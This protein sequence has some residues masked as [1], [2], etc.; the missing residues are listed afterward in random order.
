MRAGGLAAPLPP[1]GEGGGTVES[2]E[3]AIGRIKGA[4]KKPRCGYGHKNVVLTLVD[5]DT[6]T[7]RSFHVANT[8]TAELGPIVRRN[9]SREAHL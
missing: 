9:L 8:T 5:R 2:D 1:M 6:K 3:T 4:L 7:V